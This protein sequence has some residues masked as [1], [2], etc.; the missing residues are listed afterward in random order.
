MFQWMQKFFNN[1]SLAAPEPW[2]SDALVRKSNSGQ[3]VT[4]ETALK[5]SA[6]YA[7]TRVIAESVAQLPLNIYRKEN[8]GDSAVDSKHPLQ[9]LLHDMPNSEMS[10]FDLH[11]FNISKI[12]FRGTSYTQINRTGVGKVGELI[13]LTG[14]VKVDRDSRGKLYYFHTTLSGTEEVLRAEQV[15]RIPGLS[16][17]GIT[18]LTPI[19][20]A[21][22]S[23]GMALASD[24]H[25]SRMLANGAVV[26]S[27]VEIPDALS[28]QAYERV[29]QHFNENHVGT[30]N[31]GKPM[32]L[33]EGLKFKNI[34]LNNVDAQFLENR[35]YQVIDITRWYRVPPHMI[36]ELDNATFS[37]IEHQ[38]IYFLTHTLNVWLKRYTQ[39]IY[40][41]LLTPAE[42]QTH[43]ADFVVEALLRADS[44]SRFDAY[45]K[46]IQNSML[47]PNE[48]RVKENLPREEGLDVFYSPGNLMT[49]EQR[50]STVRQ[51]NLIRNAHR[52]LISKEK[53]S[54]TTAAKKNKG[55][56]LR[57]WAREFY[58]NHIST[59]SEELQLSESESKNYCDKQ[60]KTVLSHDWSEDLTQDLLKVALNAN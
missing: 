7:C 48:A 5:V 18:G 2:L 60:L 30:M 19:G 29:K 47:T 4:E 49:A 55:D 33:E 31:A 11:D 37:N 35:K 3:V 8:N 24:E 22:E 13:P 58:K 36:G 12:L 20:L 43:F 32:L 53:Q 42:R 15:W 41:D 27:V 10:A 25:G 54:L 23:I 14:R 40:R 6:V 17:D 16:I 34:G 38:G 1:S 59:V 26:P 50:E 9:T 57:N 39:S 52:R 56:E 21:R 45:V 51:E 46:Q 44:E 28:D